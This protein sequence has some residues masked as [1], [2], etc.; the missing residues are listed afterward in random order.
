M[1]LYDVIDDSNFWCMKSK[2]LPLA[3]LIAP[4]AKYMIVATKTDCERVV[5]TEVGLHLC[6]LA[7]SWHIRR[8]L[9]MERQL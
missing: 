2:W 3:K 5:S 7:R 9:D 6:R 4:K 1:V 8:G